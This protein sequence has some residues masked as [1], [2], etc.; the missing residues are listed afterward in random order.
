MFAE[1][2]PTESAILD[3]AN[4]HGQLGYGTNIV[5]TS[6]G[7]RSARRETFDDWQKAIADLKLA[8]TLWDLVGAHNDSALIELTSK[9]KEENLPIALENR[10][11]LNDADPAMPA[12]AI[13]RGQCDLQLSREVV[14]RMLFEGDSTRLKISLEPQSLRAGMWLQFAIAINN[15]KRYGKCAQCGT[16]FE[17]SRDKT[18]G[19]RPDAQFCGPR[20]RVHRYRDRIESARRMSASGCSPQEIARALK[21]QIRTV[22]GWLAPREANR[23]A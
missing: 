23:R 13:V 2:K 19:K 1:L 4:E 5:P 21:T 3:F 9:L 8:I 18:T 6:F 22:N 14:S 10:L 16:A 7:D 20:C 15:L 11:H 12:L 17:V